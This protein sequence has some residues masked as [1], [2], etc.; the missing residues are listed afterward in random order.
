MAKYRFTHTPAYPES[1]CC[2]VSTESLLFRLGT[3]TL[4]GL[5]C[6]IRVH[7][8]FPSRK[9]FLCVETGLS[10]LLPDSF[11]F[12]GFVPI[13]EKHSTQPFASQGSWQAAQ[14]LCIHT[15]W[16]AWQL[17]SVNPQR[18]APF[19]KSGNKTLKTRRSQK[20]NLMETSMSHL[21]PHLSPCPSSFHISVFMKI[22]LREACDALLKQMKWRWGRE[23]L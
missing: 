13:E 22:K 11:H 7:K 12:C 10:R 1:K 18:H 6:M 19:L 23:L 16:V 20:E 14:C 2:F 15:G 3:C 9:A 4:S 21:P 17:P 8:H 5:Y